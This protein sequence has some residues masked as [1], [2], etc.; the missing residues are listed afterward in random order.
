MGPTSGLD[1]SGRGKYAA[2][3]VSLRF[4]CRK[5]NFGASV[6]NVVNSGFSPF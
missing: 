4:P 1:V 3:L 2:T 5:E 6:K